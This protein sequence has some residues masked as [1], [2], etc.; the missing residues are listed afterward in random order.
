M[1]KT[2]IVLAVLFWALVMSNVFAEEVNETLVATDAVA[3]TGAVAETWVVTETGAV[4][5]TGV[6]AETGAVAETGVVAETGA[7]AETGVVAETGAI[8][9]T[10]TVEEVDVNA[11]IYAVLDEFFERNAKTYSTFKSK[12][13]FLSKLKERVVKA[14]ET[15]KPKF[16]SSYGVLSSS[17]ESYKIK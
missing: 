6:V 12:S 14:S 8:A 16:K 11:Q 4:A 17:L 2:S 15:A 3:E 9:E 7:V 10:G 5:E 13:D 1:K